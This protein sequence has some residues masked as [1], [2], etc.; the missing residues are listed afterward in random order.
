LK[1]CSLSGSGLA[2][3]GQHI[4]DPRTGKPAQRLNRAWALAQT[5]AES[6]ALSTACMVWDEVEMSA[7]VGESGDWLVF[8]ETA[9][10]WRCL[11]RREAPMR[12]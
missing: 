1:N 5:A 11:G 8:L 7:V 12:A 6:D 9:E 10:S 2:V 4:F 3:K